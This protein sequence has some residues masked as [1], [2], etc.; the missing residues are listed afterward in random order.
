MSEAIL[1]DILTPEEAAG[2]LKIELR[3]LLKLAKR[4]E[5]PAK[6][7]GRG[8]YR[9]KASVIKEWFENWHPNIYN[10]NKRAGEIIEA[11]RGKKKKGL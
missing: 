9:F 4:G 11:L 7:I 8:D 10:P 5:I 1:N 3:R 2:F 6:K